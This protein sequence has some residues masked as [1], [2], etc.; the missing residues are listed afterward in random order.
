M[1]CYFYF[2]GQPGPT[3]ST[4]N[5]GGPGLPGATG[6]TG[7]SGPAGFTGASGLPGSIGMFIFYCNSQ[8]RIISANQRLNFN[9]QGLYFLCVKL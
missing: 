8:I 6:I 3:G 9:V 1:F 5:P 4:G 7:P 2:S